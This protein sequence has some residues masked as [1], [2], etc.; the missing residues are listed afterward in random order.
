M[1]SFAGGCRGVPCM[2]AST[3][4]ETGQ[5]TLGYKCYCSYGYTGANCQISIPPGVDP[6]L[7]NQC[8]NRGACVAS[9][10][11]YSCECAVGY[12]GQFCTEGTYSV[13]CGV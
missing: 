8:E 12:S 2:H 9:G 5:E 10:T 13:G 4:V 6:C 3:C 11:A 7:F 1:S